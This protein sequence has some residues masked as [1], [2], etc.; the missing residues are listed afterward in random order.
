MEVALEAQLRQNLMI[1]KIIE[2]VM[3]GVPGRWSVK[4]RVD[5]NP[6]WIYFPASTSFDDDRIY[7][8]I[9]TFTYHFHD[10]LMILCLEGQEMFIL[11]T[12]S[13]LHNL[14]FGGT[15][16]RVAIGLQVPSVP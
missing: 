8:D 1:C 5:D 12:T 9:N 15:A 3:Y 11:G 6:V 7:F 10:S 14:P 13:C 2:E 4:L 16:L